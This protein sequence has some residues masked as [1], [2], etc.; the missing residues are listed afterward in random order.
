MKRLLFL[1]VLAGCSP[2]PEEPPV[3]QDPVVVYAA[4]EDD[5]AIVEAFDRYKEETGV[6]VIV[7]RGP[8]ER[9]VNDLITDNI[10]PPADL[11]MTRAVV[12][13]WHAAEEGALRP[14]TSDSVAQRVPEWARDPDG[15]WIATGSDRVVFAYSGD[16]PFAPQPVDLTHDRF[17]GKLCLSSSRNAIN[18]ALIASLIGQGGEL[19]VIEKVVRGWVRN[20]ALP[21]FETEAQLLAAIAEGRCGVGIVTRRAAI[22]SGVSYLEPR[23]LYTDVEAIGVAR[24]ARN[25][26]GAAAL[27]EWLVANSRY[28]EDKAPVLSNIGLV[29]WHYEDAVKLAERAR[30]P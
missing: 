21:P 24:H 4:F 8:A 29:A 13:A 20:L 17:H 30:Y 10:S 19:R 11:F 9:I 16:E 5:S 27:A 2:A 23:S 25:P 12:D 14:L 1:L 18:R 3:R 22:E 15:L 6:L 26:E 28:D 7:R